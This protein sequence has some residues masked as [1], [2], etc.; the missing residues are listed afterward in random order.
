MHT[1][2][3]QESVIEICLSIT[4][5]LITTSATKLT[6]TELFL[7][8]NKPQTEKMSHPESSQGEDTGS[9]QRQQ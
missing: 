1:V 9:E 8:I 2:M 4:C 6:L 7:L 5:E 3:R